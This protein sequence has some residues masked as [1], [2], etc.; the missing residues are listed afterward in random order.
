MLK[1]APIFNL[2]K[3]I[4]LRDERPHI[5]GRRVSVA[6]IAHSAQTHGWDVPT[7]CEQFTLSQTEVLSA[8]LYYSEYGVQIE[9]QEEAY[10]HEL[11]EA[12]KAFDERQNR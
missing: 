4:E 9:A 8:L 11:D 12:Q 6:T 10:Q 5:R 3:Y 2:S 1:E 7:L